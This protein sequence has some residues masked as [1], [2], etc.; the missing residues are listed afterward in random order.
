MKEIRVLINEQ[1]KEN[2]VKFLICIPYTLL[3]SIQFNLTI[4]FMLCFPKIYI[5]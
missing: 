5:V 2:H 4:L 3:I 1:S